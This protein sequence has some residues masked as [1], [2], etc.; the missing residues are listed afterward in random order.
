[1]KMILYLWLMELTCALTD[2]LMTTQFTEFLTKKHIIEFLYN[3]IQLW[4]RRLRL[5]TEYIL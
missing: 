2:F 1:M 3:I 5:L 4:D